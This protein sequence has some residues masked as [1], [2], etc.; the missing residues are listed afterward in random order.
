MLA[1]TLA[2]DFGAGSKTL[3][4]INQDGYSSEYYLRETL[5]DY[6]LSFRHS[7]TTRNGI[8]YD[9]HNA[10]VVVTV[11]ATTTTPQYERKAY[12]VFEAMP[13][14]SV[15][16][17]LALVGLNALAAAST[18]ALLVSLSGWES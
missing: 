18:N 5:L 13:G 17:H 14:D 12:F 11:F 8:T 10:E 9:R 6:R 4:R 2:I 1:N 15:A 3:T 7:R 16:Q